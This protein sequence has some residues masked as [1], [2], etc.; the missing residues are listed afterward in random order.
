M[1]T[2][3]MKDQQENKANTM[4]TMPAHFDGKQIRLD[5]PDDEREG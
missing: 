3:E 2:P 5:K 4:I 1:A